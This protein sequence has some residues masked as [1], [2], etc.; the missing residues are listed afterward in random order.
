MQPWVVRVGCAVRLDAG[1][2]VH[3]KRHV[4]RPHLLDAIRSTTF[5]SPPRRQP[6]APRTTPLNWTCCNCILSGSLRMASQPYPLANMAGSAVVDPAFWAQPQ[7]SADSS[8]LALHLSPSTSSTTQGSQHSSTSPALTPRSDAERKD[9]Q[10]SQAGQ[11]N[12][13]NGQNGAQAR[14]SVAVACVPCR[15]RHLKCDGGVRCSRCRADGVD[16]TYIKSRRGWKGKRK[17]PGEHGAPQVP[18][19]SF[20]PTTNALSLMSA[21]PRG[22]HSAIGHCAQYQSLAHQRPVTL[23]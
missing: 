4:M 5:T 8:P 17:K 11:Q 16:C 9:S 22:H 12:G 7:D 19:P 21:R 18:G 14:T 13:Q 1:S 3:A 6:V 15:S 10:A 23:T 20:P 2:T